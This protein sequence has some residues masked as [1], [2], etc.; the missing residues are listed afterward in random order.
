MRILLVEDEERI[1]A[2]IHKGLR[3]EL[4][5]V[6]VARD[7]AEALDIALAS[8]YDLI[9]LDVRLPMR[10]GISVCRE[11][12]AQGNR[13]PILMLTARDTVDDRV[14]G[15]DA[16]ADDYLVK[17]FAFQELLARL[18]ALARRPPVVQDHTLRVENLTLDTRTHQTRRDAQPIDLSA[19]EYRLLELLMR[20]PGQV[21]TRTQIA[22]HI[23]GYDFDAN[24]NVVD[25][26][27]RYLRRKVDDPFE[28]KLIQTVRGVG[29]KLEA[30]HG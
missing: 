18:R 11:L 20:H 23:W 1:A 28:P 27:I 29:Y 19:R 21:L 14:R 16:G 4:Y 17:P 25:V 5:T 22:E 6:D 3:E 10:D 26:Y 8:E 30:S 24:S 7:G 13:T 15:L 9:V 2:F 12:R